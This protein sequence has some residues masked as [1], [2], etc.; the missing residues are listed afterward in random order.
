M[1]VRIDIITLWAFSSNLSW[2]LWHSLKFLKPFIS[3]GQCCVNSG[4][5]SKI[6]SFILEWHLLLYVTEFQ[7]ILWLLLAVNLLSCQS[8][9]KKKRLCRWIIHYTHMGRQQ[10]LFFAFWSILHRCRI[11]RSLIAF[12]VDMATLRRWSFYIFTRGVYDLSIRLLFFFNK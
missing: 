1:H 9:L 6:R 8:Y 10:H 5:P 11:S 7:L 3:S 2:T 12:L 4:H